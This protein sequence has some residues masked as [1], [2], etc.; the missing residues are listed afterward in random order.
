MKPTVVF[1]GTRCSFAD[2]VLQRLIDAGYNIVAR[3]VPAPKNLQSPYRKLASTGRTRIGNQL[4]VS[5]HA[6]IGDSGN[7]STP[8]VM[9]SDHAAPESRDFVRSLEPDVAVVCCYPVRLPTQLVS[10]ARHGGMNVHPSLLPRYRGPEPLFWVFR[11]GERK[12]GVTLHT[13]AAKLDAGRIVAQEEIALADD[14]AGDR[15][16]IDS[17]ELGA[18][19]LERVL[20]DLDGFLHGATPQDEHFASYQ[21]WPTPDDLVINPDQWDAERIGRFVH[22]VL[23]LG[24]VPNLQHA[25]KLHPVSGFESSLSAKHEWVRCKTGHVA[26]RISD[27]AYLYVER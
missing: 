5:N 9:M 21:S 15:L 13:V 3:I 24:Y 18:R 1:F 17:A 20:A 2:L 4:P 8:I 6:G 12:T 19:M 10:I 22:G 16:W 25:G 23:P 11:N 26:V 7:Q 14:T 27:G